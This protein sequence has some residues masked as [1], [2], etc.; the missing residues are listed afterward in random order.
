MA[1]NLESA[2]SPENGL[3]APTSEIHLAD[4]IGVLARRWKWVV[5]LTLL[6]PG[7]VFAF[8]VVAPKKFTARAVVLMETSDV[9]VG[10]FTSELVTAGKSDLYAR[11]QFYT[12]ERNLIQSRANLKSVVSQ[13]EL[14]QRCKLAG[15]DSVEAL[16]HALEVKGDAT[17]KL[18]EVRVE[19]AEAQCAA[20]LANAVVNS[21]VQ[22][23]LDEVRRKFRDDVESLAPEL[24]KLRQDL[25]KS[26]AEGEEYKQEH[27]LVNLDAP[28]GE[29]MKHLAELESALTE[30]QVNRIQIEKRY[31]QARRY[32]SDPS[33]VESLPETLASP[34]VAKL[35]Q[36]YLSLLA[37]QADL[38]QR[39]RDKHPKMLQL[40]AQLDE[41]AKR[42]RDEVARVI[43]GL[44][45]EH[46]TAIERERALADEVELARQST[47][48]K[49]ARASQAHLLSDE[50]SA[51]R[52]LFE[53]VSGKVIEA[54]IVSNIKRN[55]VR[56]VDPAEVPRDPSFPDTQ[57]YVLLGLAVGLVLGLT[58][59]FASAA[60]DQTIHGVRDLTRAA[61]I[62]FGET[63]P[64]SR[65]LPRPGAAAN[66]D[67]APELGAAFAR[68]AALVELE[69]SRRMPSFG[70]CQIVAVVGC[71]GGEGVTTTSIGLARAAAAA[72]RRV[73]AV[74]AHP[75]DSVLARELGADAK[76]GLVEWVNGN[77]SLESLRQSSPVPGV[78]VLAAGAAIGAQALIRP[79][80]VQAA[81]ATVG[82]SHDLIVID[83]PPVTRSAAAQVLARYADLVLLVVETD[84]TVRDELDAACR[85]LARVEPIA[86]RV[87]L[88]RAV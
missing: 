49:T 17:S 12:T 11:A 65:M 75:G 57:L 59:A 44:E 60:L 70:S 22:T 39:Y 68:V 55:N 77:A 42:I 30:A 52:Q 63:V 34:V 19:H 74:D 36:T 21:Y 47:R 2:A 3:A 5:G 24:D 46:Q 58:G 4:Y 66:A 28:A 71:A 41:L 86:A 53:Q 51:R 14:W 84:R 6:V 50:A 45:I 16:D 87:I 25:T 23:N 78:S 33:R 76:S 43:D 80:R 62:P 1:S 61:R 69:R 73:L 9:S 32:A 31:E 54:K 26:V 13:A 83:L 38:S 85:E 67:L 81:F 79:D 29:D 10:T 35:R 48:Q 56:V 8:C 88:N 72:G 15:A 64:A 82:S 7:L 27:G 37:E 40:R 20:D 18:S